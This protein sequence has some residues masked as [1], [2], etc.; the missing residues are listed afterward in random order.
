MRDQRQPV[1]IL[2]TEDDHDGLLVDA[3]MLRQALQQ[4]DFFLHYQ[5]QFDLKSGQRVGA[6]ALLRWQHPSRGVIPP[7]NFVPMLEESGL[8]VPVGEWVLKTAC[9]QAAAWH[10]GA[11]QS[12]KI[13][14]NLSRV[15]FEQASLVR[16]VRN[17]LAE[18]GLPANAL[19]LEI[20]ESIAMND[21]DQVVATLNELRELGVS[22]AIDDFG[23]GYSS[24]ACLKHFPVDK[25]K[26]D[27]S[28][29]RGIDSDPRDQTIVSAIIGMAK[30][31][32]LVVVAEGVESSAH[33]DFLRE[34]HCE[35]GQGYYLGRPVLPHKLMR[36]P[37][38]VD[39]G[40][41]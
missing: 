28:F 18:S 35:Q 2:I 19:E 36:E 30:A 34:H 37:V 40:H 5:P 26:I 12:I 38:S 27:Q 8:I 24:L 41:T 20:T 21:Q 15:Q 32:D 25:L 17:A 14:V 13:A 1:R 16:T 31:L 9:H 6:E 33:V 22:L 10:C 23:T 39:I 29:I 7:A 11:D 3:G 4:G